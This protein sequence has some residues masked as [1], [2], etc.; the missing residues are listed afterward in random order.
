MIAALLISAPV[1][2]ALLAAASLR[3]QSPVSSLLA[4]YLVFVADLGLATWLLSPL[5]AVDR[6]GLAVVE[7]VLLAGAVV[8]WWR[9]GKPGLGLRRALPSVRAIVGDPVCVV[10]L[11]ALAALLIYELVLV[12]AAPADNWDSL[13]YHLSR[14][15]AWRQHG[16]VY[17]IPNAPTP[18]MNEYQPLAEQQ[19]LYLFVA[20]GTGALFGLPQYLAQLAI[21]LAVYGASR[22]LGFGARPAA[23]AAALLATF[24]LVVLQSSTAQNDLVA[25]SFP[26]AALCLLLGGG[27]L[28][29]SLAGFAVGIGVGAKLTIVLV[30]PVL[31]LLA[32]A[33]G[34]RRLLA[35]LGGCAAGFVAIGVWGFAINLAN[36]GHVLGYL[37]THIETPPG[38]QPIHTSA[39]ATSIDV[40]YE[41]FDLSLF[42]DHQIR[43]LWIGAAIAGVAVA[44]FTL[45][46]GGRRSTLVA[47]A[48][49]AA[50]LLAPLLMVHGGGLVA[51]LARSWGFPIRGHLGNIGGLNRTVQNSAF[52]PVGALAFLGAPLVTAAAWFL[53]RA[54]RRQLAIAASVPLFYLLLGHETFNYFMTRF[55]IVPAALVAPLFAR[56]FVNRAATVAFL[57]LAGLVAW[58][59]VTQDPMRPA[60]SGYGHPWQ[61]SQ[62]DAAYLTGEAGVGDAVAAYRRLVPRHACVGA[63][64]GSDEPAYFLFGPT[65]QHRVVFLPVTGALNAAYKHLLTFVVI[66]TG[67]DRWAAGVFRNGGWT[68]S[69]LGGYWL[70]ATAP[71]PGDGT[72]P[73]HEQP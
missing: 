68:I 40:L 72:C 44:V 1:A 24:S 46:R 42:S 48:A 25:A 21:L 43:L 26:A 37:G 10:F 62:V 49:V 38:E 57:A 28:E 8:V 20:A 12:L 31:L 15:A 39:A 33:R 69:P 51:W 17:R 23:C 47:G 65:L 29:S 18:R 9:R 16:G 67:P 32:V 60:N 73:R 22:R 59:S 66:S 2:V 6:V 58:W 14:V 61:L 36:T 7:S 71:H 54:D 45:R 35:G 30:V 56:F 53:R 70:L 3:L 4:A 11:A 34:R 50:P 27:L 19:I 52:G 13:T 5:R 63:V 64:L 55:L 41:T